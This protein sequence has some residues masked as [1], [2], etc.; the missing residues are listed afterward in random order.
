VLDP[1]TKDPLAAPHIYLSDFQ[2]D[3]EVAVF[4]DYQEMIKSG[5]V[6]AVNDFTSLLMHHQVGMAAVDAGEVCRARSVT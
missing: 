2:P 5:K 4:T 6:D 3:T 1:E